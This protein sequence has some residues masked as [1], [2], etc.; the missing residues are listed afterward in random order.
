MI[1]VSLEWMNTKIFII[2]QSNLLIDLTEY[3]RRKINA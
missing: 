1:I 3:N 2:L